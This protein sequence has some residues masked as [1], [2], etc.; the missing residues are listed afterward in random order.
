[1]DTHTIYDLLERLANQL[2]TESRRSGSDSGLQPI[3][4]DA[5][6]YLSRCNR[7]SDTPLGVTDYLGLTKG[8]VSQTLKVLE[9]KNLIVK[10]ADSRDKRVVHLSLSPAGRTLL[11]ECLP[12]PSLNAGLVHLCTDDQQQL[13]DNLRALLRG[14]QI[15][16]NMKS[17]AQC[18]SCQHNQNIKTGEFFC[19]LTQEPLSN[20]DIELI[21]REHQPRNS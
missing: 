6:Y 21:C 8:T 4:L 16:N 11:A 3:Q 5:L 19:G 18:K 10:Q 14:M 1:M 20:T 13:H 15:E 7:Y 12:P 17:F 2:R 9:G